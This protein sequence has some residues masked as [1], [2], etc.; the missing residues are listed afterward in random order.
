ML[1]SSSSIQYSFSVLF[2]YS[3]SLCLHLII[4]GFKYFLNQNGRNTYLFSD[5]KKT[6][7]AK[8]KA[9]SPVVR[10]STANMRVDFENLAWHESAPNDL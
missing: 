8:R 6:L 1:Q 9:P 5:S 7:L 10:A 4:E 3:K 2:I